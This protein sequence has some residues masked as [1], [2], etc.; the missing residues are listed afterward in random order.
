MGPLSAA[1]LNVGQSNDLV[2]L[3]SPNVTA[4]GRSRD[5]TGNGVDY[6]SFCKMYLPLHNISTLEEGGGC[7]TCVKF[8][9]HPIPLFPFPTLP[10]FPI[11]L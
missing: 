10:C 9:G 5:Q 2:A 1:P 7:L 8:V 11:N 3:T 4:R 6:F